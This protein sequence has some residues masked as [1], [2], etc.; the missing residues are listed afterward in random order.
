MAC[1]WNTQNMSLKNDNWYHCPT[2]IFDPLIGRSGWN[3]TNE[4][5]NFVLLAVM[6]RSYYDLK[7]LILDD[8]H[9]ISLIVSCQHW[10]RYGLDAIRRQQAITW[11]TVDPDLCL[12]L[13]LLGHN[14]L[15]HLAPRRC[16]CSLKLMIFKF[17]SRMDILSVSSEIA[18]RL[19]P[20]NTFDNKSI[21][22]QVMTWCHQTTSYYLS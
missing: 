8:Y 13:A 6:F 10:F 20:Q 2:L 19:I 4:I 1:T 14:E 7:A 21:L 18:L 22:A 3:S 15:T 17:I 16:S 5:S 11:A 12:H 9:R